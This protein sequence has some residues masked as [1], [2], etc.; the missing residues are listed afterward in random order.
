MPGIFLSLFYAWAAL[1]ELELCD[2]AAAERGMKE[3]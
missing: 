3:E 1:R 2:P